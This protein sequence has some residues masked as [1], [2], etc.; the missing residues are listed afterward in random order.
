MT[1]IWITYMGADMT[2][3]CM[4]AYMYICYFLQRE[5]VTGDTY[6][7]LVT[8]KHVTAKQGTSALFKNR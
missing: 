3:V 4:Y 5:Y 2:F 6:K 7:A 1:T 8:Q